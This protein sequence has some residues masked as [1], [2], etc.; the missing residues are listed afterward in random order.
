M[1]NPGRPVARCVESEFGEDTAQKTPLTVARVAALTFSILSAFIVY[2]TFRAFENDFYEGFAKGLP[3]I[4]PFYSPFIPVKGIPLLTPALLILPGPA[5]FRLTCYYHRRAYYRSFAMDPPACAVGERGTPPVQR[6]D[7][8]SPLSRTST[9]FVRS[10]SR[11]SF[12]GFLWF[13]FLPARSSR[14]RRLPA[15]RRNALVLLPELHL[16]QPVHVRLPLVPAPRRW[17]AEHVPGRSRRAPLPAV[18]DRDDGERAAHAVRLG[19]PLRSGAHRLLRSVRSPAARSPT[20]ASSELPT[21]G[22]RVP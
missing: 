4:S 20:F 2:A 15:W 10:T 14:D 8:A 9:R 1:A 22:A 6:R 11:S 17:R 5:T 7:E 19:E 18:E 12:M 21:R 16:A 3:Y 13:D